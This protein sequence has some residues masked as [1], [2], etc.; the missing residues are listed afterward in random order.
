MVVSAILSPVRRVAGLLTLGY[1]LLVFG[2][3]FGAQWLATAYTSLRDRLVLAVVLGSAGSNLYAIGYYLIHRPE[4]TLGLLTGFNGLGTL[5]VLYTGVS[6]GYLLNL[7]GGWRRLTLPYLAVAFSALLLTFSRGA[8]LGFL[9]M[10]ATF[11]LINRCSRRWAVAGLLAVLLVLA[12]VPTVAERFLTSFQPSANLSRLYIWRSTLMMIKDYPLFGV[13]AGAFM[14]VYPRYVLPGAPEPVAAFAHNLF[15]QVLAEFGLV[16]FVVFVAIL[17]R[18]M[19]MSWQLARTG[20][21]FYQGIFAALVGVL[22]HQ[23]VDIPIWGLEIGGA[24]WTMVGL[25]IALYH[26]ELGPG[27]TALAR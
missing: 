21:V 20:N 24:F 23:Q 13:G 25:V 15:L 4:R 5:I 11:A 6:L 2:F 18:V 19:W 22:I 12:G 17:G 10:I 16:G 14:H 9:G 1:A 3:V 8:W 7:R 26:R 27:S